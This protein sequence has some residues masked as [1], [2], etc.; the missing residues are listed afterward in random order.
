M[1][2]LHGDDV[3]GEVTTRN[4]RKSFILSDTQE[5]I[6]NNVIIFVFVLT[7]RP[8]NIGQKVGAKMG[9]CI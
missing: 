6:D 1:F 4:G 8:S 5:A 9:E 3:F 2:S 7:S